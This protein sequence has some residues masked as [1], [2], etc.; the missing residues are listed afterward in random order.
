MSGPVVLHANQYQFAPGQSLHNELVGSR[1]LLWCRQGAGRIEVDGAVMP[2]PADAWTLLTWRHRI[3]YEAD[4]RRPFVVCGIHICPDHDHDVAVEMR[5][6]H[7]RDDLQ[8][9]VRHRRNIHWPG[10][11]GRPA[12]LMS[13]S[14]RLRALGDYI[15][16]RWTDQMVGSDQARAMAVMLV[17][18]LQSAVGAGATDRLPDA[19]ARTVTLVQTRL[20]VRHDL[21]RLAAAAGCS[22]P[23]LVRLFRQHLQRS[24]M[25][26]LR[27]QRISS[28][29]RLLST[30]AQPVAMIGATVG[31]PDRQ[32][33]AK[34]FTQATGMSPRAWR[35]RQRL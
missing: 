24:P 10:L 16:A 3:R 1:M 17:D 34:V 6:P 28:A 21:G 33:F 20:S 22:V 11:D 32:R 13:A 5:V 15:I 9:Q 26:W 19:L 31:I 14:P 4:R 18:E 2:L 12:G 25:A 35:Q 8:H 23:S 27:D 30:T 29:R 7:A